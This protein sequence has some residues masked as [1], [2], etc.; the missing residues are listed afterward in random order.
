MARCFGTRSGNKDPVRSSTSYEKL[1]TIVFVLSL[2]LCNPWVRG[3]GVGYYGMARS[4]LIE[5]RLDF[6]E[7]WLRA[8][9][10]F[11]M[12]RMDA[13][14]HILP[15]QYTRTGQLDN[16]YSIG[17]AI[18]WAPF[19]IVAHVGVRLYD[20]AGGHVSADGYSKPYLFAMAFGSAFYGFLALWISFCLARRYISER[21]AFLATLGI[22]FGSSLP[23]Y[24]YFNPSW[25]HA[26]SA[27]VVALFVWY[28][29]VTRH[30]RTRTQWMALGAIGGLMLDVYYINVVLLLLPLMESLVG[31]SV[32]VKMRSSELAYRLFFKNAL[33]AALLIAIFSPTL[34][35]KKVI[36]G[37]FLNVGYPE[38]W[39]WKSP[40]LLKVCFSS[41][42][43]LFSWTPILVLA[44]IGLFALRKVD[45]NLAIYSIMGLATY[46]YVIGCYQ[47]W[48]GIS[49]FGNRF[50][51][52]L[53]VLFILGLA[54]GLQWLAGIWQERRAF[55]IASA[56]T[57]LMVFWNIGLIFQWGTHMIPARGPVSWRDVAYNQVAVVPAQAAS[58]LRVY[59]TG[60]TTLMNHIEQQDLIQLKA[61]Q[62][63]ENK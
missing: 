13:S 35:T 36:Y 52:S 26:H 23:V 55:V 43:G 21:M 54:A 27:F 47:D 49:S 56:A 22:W 20:I 3:D 32:A 59:L 50:F 34:I 19:L 40:A 30:N 25:S 12:S 44:A 48:D 15:K 61:K 60:R 45:R 7:D 57:A 18:L 53:T 39:Y 37:S 14:G 17:P 1:L 58:S 9:S 29:T 62:L 16:H 4:L 6:R 11:Q 51:V 2:P 46:I 41:D 24:M 42:H 5:H 8:N 63:Q 10:S 33:F 31:Y 38:R 28:W